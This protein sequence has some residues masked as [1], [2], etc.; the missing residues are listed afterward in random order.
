[1]IKHGDVYSGRPVYAS[2]STTT[3]TANPSVSAVQS[4]R[5]LR[6]KLIARVAYYFWIP[7][8]V[9]SMYGIGYQ[10]GI[11]DFSCDPDKIKSRLLDTILAS[12]WSSS[13]RA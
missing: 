13:G 7:F 2:L 1:M 11:M 5:Q 12:V 3:A 9:L 10:W 4:K 8:L 6:F